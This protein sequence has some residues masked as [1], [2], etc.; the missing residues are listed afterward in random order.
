MP[1]MRCQYCELTLRP[2]RSPASAIPHYPRWVVDGQP[3]RLAVGNVPTGDD[4]DLMAEIP[5]RDPTGPEERG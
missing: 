5:I 3:S 2:P 4:Y 1:I